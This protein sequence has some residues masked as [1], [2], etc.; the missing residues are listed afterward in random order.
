MEAFYFLYN[1][2]PLLTG[3][4][5]RGVLRSSRVRSS[6]KLLHDTARSPHNEQG[7]SLAINLSELR[8]GY[9]DGVLAPGVCGGESTHGF[10]GLIEAIGVL[11]RNP[12]SAVLQQP[13]QAL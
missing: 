10:P 9:P 1:H 3:V 4:S 13:T 8:S 6:S 7:P 12:E 11:D 2:F 5:G